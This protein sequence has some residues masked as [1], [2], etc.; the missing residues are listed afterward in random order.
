MS[1][2][3]TLKMHSNLLYHTIMRQAGTIAKAVLEGIMNSVDAKATFCD[4]ELTQDSLVIMD[5]GC[6]FKDSAEIDEFFETFGTPHEEGDATYGTFRM[7]RG[8]LFAFG[9]N[10][11]TSGEFKMDVDIKNKGLEY[12]FRCGQPRTDGCVIEVALYD[13]LSRI[14]LA[15]N[16]RTIEVMAKYAP[17]NV[18]LNGT[19]ISVDPEDENWDFVTDEAYIRLKDN[20]NI[21][22]YNLGILVLTLSAWHY[23]TGGTVVSKKQ[24]KVNY[25]R[26]DIMS[27]CP[28]WKKIRTKVTSVTREK[29]E[30]KPRLN[31]DERKRLAL[32]CYE[33]ERAW[34][35]IRDKKLLTDV[36]NRP[37]KTSDIVYLYAYNNTVTAAPKGSVVG[38]RI[39]KNKMA[40]VLSEESLDRFDVK[41]VE[42]LFDLLEQGGMSPLYRDNNKINIVDFRDLAKRFNESYDIIDSNKLTFSEEVWVTVANKFMDWFNRR[43]IVVGRSERADAWT[44]GATYIA[45]NRDF[46][47]SLRYDS[48]A[49]MSKFAHV[50]AHEY[51]H[52]SDDTDS[53][54]HGP[55]FDERYRNLVEKNGFIDNFIARSFSALEDLL[56]KQ[57]RKA[58]K[59]VLQLKDKIDAVREKGAKLTAAEKRL[60]ETVRESELPVAACDK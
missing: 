52:E 6:G 13:K 26:N 29:I 27:D 43:K 10:N 46:L 38:E 60:I 4:I 59:A 24:V 28:V 14:D 8:Q 32:L 33:D 39:M 51:C 34:D 37:R 30:K 1:E 3:R 35:A 49:S 20:R 31:D 9:V 23:G 55:E 56:D 50:L 15:E 19:K 21:D 58:T 36:S 53:N 11:W 45:F 48:L 54:V 25:A 16:I 41:N 5:D 17:I 2:I 44:D 42:E 18:N 7:G 12:E 47:K 22:V 57:E 40:F